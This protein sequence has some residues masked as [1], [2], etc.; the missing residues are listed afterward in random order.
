MTS[1]EA[2]KYK[3]KIDEYAAMERGTM[4]NEQFAAG[5]IACIKYYSLV[6]AE[7]QKKKKLTVSKTKV[8]AMALKKTG[9]RAAKK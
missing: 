7:E 4:T 1:A 3:R 5:L 2:K 8:K 6:A 9:R